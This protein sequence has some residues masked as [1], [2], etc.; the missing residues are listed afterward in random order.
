[1]DS[2]NS[3]INRLLVSKETRK[4]FIENLNLLLSTGTPLTSALISIRNSEKNLTMKFFLD[5]MI[6]DAENGVALSNLLQNSNLFP[7]YT[8]SLIRIGEKTGT[9]KETLSLLLEEQ[10]KSSDFQG[11]IRSAMLYPAIVLFS[12][13]VISLFISWFMLPRLSSIFTSLHIKLPLITK[14]ILTTGNFLGEYGYFVV[15]ITFVILIFL[16]Y[17]LF[18]NEKTKHFGQSFLFVLPGVGNLLRETELARFGYLFSALLKSGIPVNQVIVTLKEATPFYNYKNFY[19]Y[20]AYS[21]E[22]GN[23][24]EQSFYSYKKIENLLPLPVQTLIISAEKT[25]RLSE[26]LE[27]LGEKYDK[28]MELTS[29]NLNAILEPIFLVIVWLV[30]IG[31]ALAVVLPIYRIIGSISSS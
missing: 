8:V 10:S 14:M 21:I 31:V 19:N 3:I 28:K 22:S 11:K 7:S 2:L 20:L 18:F 17:I 23:S 12:S 4:C 24:F 26:V 27:T 1:M 9:L 15:P 13:V 25:G 6:E 5:K 16:F 30:V 29:K